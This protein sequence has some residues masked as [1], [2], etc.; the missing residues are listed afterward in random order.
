ML[1]LCACGTR[2]ICT[3]AHAIGTRLSMSSTQKDVP[4]VGKQV[5]VSTNRKRP[6]IALEYEGER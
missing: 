3:R 4:G 5:E 6:H 2:I 1:V